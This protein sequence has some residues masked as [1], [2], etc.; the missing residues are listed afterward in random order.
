MG[1]QKSDNEHPNADLVRR[2]HAA[3]KAG[4]MATVHELFDYE[5]MV[6]TVTGNSPAGGT[7]TGMDG[8]LRNFG[9]IMAFTQ[10]TYNAAPVDYLGSDDHVVALAHVT[11]RRADGR[12]IDVPEAV[13][14]KVRNGKLVEA[15]HM[16]YDEQAWD[17]FFDGMPTWR[18]SAAPVG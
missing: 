10:G 3:F 12:T 11:A 14:F 17:S 13:V 4:D 9:D 18:S 16:A 2:A 8:V 15:Q 1:V 5:G 6:W 7:T